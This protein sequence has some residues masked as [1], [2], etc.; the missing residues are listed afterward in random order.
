MQCFE[1]ANWIAFL[2][3]ACANWAEGQN[4]APVTPLRSICTATDH[5]DE[6]HAFIKPIEGSFI[7]Q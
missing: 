6:Y 3:F 2:A 4:S 5:G 7:T 1:G